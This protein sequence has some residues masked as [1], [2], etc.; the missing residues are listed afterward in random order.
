MGYNTRFEGKFQVTPTLKQSHRKY[1]TAL[2]ETR[3]M[4]RDPSEA[5]QLPDPIRV[6]VGLSIGEDAAYFVGGTGSFWTRRRFFNC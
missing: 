3:R 6:S 4:K 5:L 1:L 2:S